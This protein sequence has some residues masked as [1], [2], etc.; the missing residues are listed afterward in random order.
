[1]TYYVLMDERAVFDIDDATELEFIGEEEP[2]KEV[3]RQLREDWGN[4][5]I[6]KVKDGVSTE[7]LIL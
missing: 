7:W 3:I 1:M 5:V 6:I 4:G 2:S